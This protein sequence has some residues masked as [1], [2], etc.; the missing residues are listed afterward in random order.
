[1]RYGCTTKQ[2]ILQKCLFWRMLKEE[3]LENKMD[4]YCKQKRQ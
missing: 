1:M 2:V 4:E 3:L